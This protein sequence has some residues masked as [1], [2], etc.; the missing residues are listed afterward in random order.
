TPRRQ[1]AKGAAL[2]WRLGGSSGN[3]GASPHTPCERGPSTD[4]GAALV[5]APAAAGR[6]WGSMAGL[7]PAGPT[8]R[9]P[10]HRGTTDPKTPG[11]RNGPAAGGRGSGR[12]AKDGTTGGI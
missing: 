9:R 6:A 3:R 11:R 1:D 12:R 8:Q 10:P 5:S 4:V 2:A 7:R